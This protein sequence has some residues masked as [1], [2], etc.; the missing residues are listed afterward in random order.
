MNIKNLNICSKCWLKES[1]KYTKYNFFKLLKVSV[2]K[3]SKV[4]YPQ[5]TEKNYK[6]KLPK[7]IKE[8]HT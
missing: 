3:Q 2:Y 4:T 6:L 1:H 7:K 8:P 5:K